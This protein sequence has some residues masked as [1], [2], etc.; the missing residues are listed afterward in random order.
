MVYFTQHKTFRLDFLWESEVISELK[1]LFRN[2]INLKSF[3]TRYRCLHV[4]P[5]TPFT[6]QT[7]VW[8]LR[9]THALYHPPLI[10]MENVLERQHICRVYDLYERKFHSPFATDVWVFF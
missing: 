4:L 1:Y 5:K 8:T 10:C 3:E 2:I 6:K 9:V 7:S